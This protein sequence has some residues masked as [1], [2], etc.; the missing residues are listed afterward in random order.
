MSKPNAETPAPTGL[1]DEERSFLRRFMAVFAGKEETTVETPAP[2][3]VS[4]EKVQSMVAAGVRAAMAEQTVAA[5]LRSVEDKATP[6]AIAKARPA[7]LKAKAAGDE[8]TY[9][10]LLGVLQEQDA[11]E[12]LGEDE[13]AS[14]EKTS[15][16][17]TLA[18]S[19]RAEVFARNGI[20]AKRE[21]ELKR[22]Y[23]YGE[24]IQ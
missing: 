9:A 12:L 17:K 19:G 4:E 22:K 5:D 23:G 10:A 20:D 13:I 2:A 3:G 11:S 16:G 18:V 24:T 6:G 15:E 1:A 14:E 8:E 21:A 7:M